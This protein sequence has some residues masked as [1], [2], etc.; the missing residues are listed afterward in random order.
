M[1]RA[2]LWSRVASM[3]IVFGTG[4]VL[5]VAAW[6]TPADGGHATHLQLGLGRCTFLT[7]TG[8]PCPMCGMT[9]TFSLL[10]HLH[11]LVAI[12]T[13]P[14][15]VVLF[16]M[17][18]SAFAIAVSEVVYPTDRWRRL[19]KTVEPYENMLATL[20][21]LGMGVGWMWKILVMRVFLWEHL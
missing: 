17:T 18:V 13:Q 1:E 5:G 7:L 2:L 12:R 16:A 20:F 21:L 15:G 4:A 8:V 3:G 9:T 10:A 19:W 11:P 6:L 14:F